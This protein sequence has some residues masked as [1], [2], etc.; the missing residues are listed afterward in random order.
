MSQELKR[1]R[2]DTKNTGFVI[3]NLGK[4]CKPLQWVR[5]L[6]ENG[7]QAIQA[8]GIDGRVVWRKHHDSLRRWGVDKL[9]CVD[10]GSGMSR[11]DMRE[12][13]GRVGSSG[14]VMAHD[15]NYGMGAKI[16]L[17]AEFQEGAEYESWQNGQGFRARLFYGDD[18]QPVYEEL[19][20][21]DP[22]EMPKEISKAGGYG[23][24]VTILGNSI[25]E[26]DTLQ[27]PP[28]VD[29]PSGWL[30]REIN[31]RYYKFPAGVKVYAP[32][33]GQTGLLEVPGQEYFISE[34]CRQSGSWELESL[35]CTVHWAI[36]PPSKKR[37]S[38]AWQFGGGARIGVLYKNELYGLHNASGAA[39]I[40]QNK[41]GIVLE[42]GKIA[43][44][45]EPHNAL[46]DTQRSALKVEGDDL[47]FDDYYQAISENLP[48]PILKMIATKLKESVDTKRRVNKMISRIYQ[49]GGIFG[50]RFVKVTNQNGKD[51]GG[52]TINGNLFSS[53]SA[54]KNGDSS[55]NSSDSSSSSTSNKRQTGS[56]ESVA[57][58]G[59]NKASRKAKD[60]GQMIPETIWVN[61]SSE[62][63]EGHFARFVEAKN[64][65]IFN[66]DFKPFKRIEKDWV[67]R[68]RD[69]AKETAREFVRSEY[70]TLVIEA[71]VAARMNHGAPSMDSEWL[72]Q[73]LSDSSLTN[74]GMLCY[75]Q[76]ADI[77]RKLKKFLSKD[78]ASSETAD[79]KTE[80]Q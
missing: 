41:C 15:Q 17:L 49:P 33:S 43:M 51:T 63:M 3:S 20:P 44:F 70:E 29:I 50:R 72:E 45:L 23:T 74:L 46:P 1:Y 38:R 40:L 78:N 67:G 79:N 4:D 19:G 65:L 54:H 71:V 77:S 27:A 32:H 73:Q 5:E 42:A 39:A 37:E 18:D 56:Q 31:K 13:V 66:K 52:E 30:M 7:I 58:K 36:V 76:E 34:N 21:V 68:V 24:V 25:K 53:N 2:I 9:C 48:E 14:R 22:S 26:H 16:S 64:L 28:G 61:G 57:G 62:S 10:T 11:E 59:K 75:R 80:S 60:P 35:N 8:R 69:D 55:G 47:P 6:T 12:W